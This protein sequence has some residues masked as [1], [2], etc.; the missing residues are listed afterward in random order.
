MH[1]ICTRPIAGPAGHGA[2]AAGSAGRWQP[3]PAWYVCGE[4]G[5][6]RHDGTS[7]PAIP[8]LLR[9]LRQC[10]LAGKWAGVSGNAMRTSQ[11]VVSILLVSPSIYATNGDL[12]LL[13][14]G[15]SG[16]G[17]EKALAPTWS[18]DPIAKPSQLRGWG[19]G[20]GFGVR[21]AAR[22]LA[23]LATIAA[24]GCIISL[25][26]GLFRG[27]FSGTVPVAV[28]SDRAGLVMNPDAKVELHGVQVGR[29]ASIDSRPD[30]MA[31]ES[32]HGPNPAE[33]FQ[34]TYAST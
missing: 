8:E 23:G 12:S 30:G 9:L 20:R 28:I 16:V 13:G 18:T 19:T 24:V 7:G 3:L 11:I 6:E 32:G 29:V 22:P 31:V 14:Y 33:S 17:R 10:W 34:R 21:R 26:V 4:Q 15:G 25:A 5:W 27:S 2:G 1:T